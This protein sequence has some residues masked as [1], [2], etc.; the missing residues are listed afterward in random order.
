MGYV[1]PLTTRDLADTGVTTK[2]KPSQ[3]ASVHAF[4]AKE[5]DMMPGDWA[6]PGLPT[7]YELRTTL[8]TCRR[9]WQQ[10]MDALHHRDCDR[11]VTLQNIHVL[12]KL[13]IHLMD[14][15]V[16]E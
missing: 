13:H 4:N 3:P 9:L 7:P 16:D 1:L 2:D 10:N 11:E 12:E 8:H 15:L 6:E 14:Y 5:I